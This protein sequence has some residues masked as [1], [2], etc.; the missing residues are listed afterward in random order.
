MK[1]QEI[2]WPSDA[3]SYFVRQG[4]TVE[5]AVRSGIRPVTKTQV[6]NMG[7]HP[8]LDSLAIPYFDPI[9]G[10]RLETLRFRYLNPPIIEGEL[11]R[12]TQSA[13]TPVEAYFDPAVN[14]RPILK[15]PRVDLLITEGEFKAIVANKY[16][17]WCIAL[18]GVDS[19]HQKDSHLLTPL[20]RKVV[21]R[22]RRVFICYDSDAATNPNVQR[23]ERQLAE[24]LSNA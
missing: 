12:Y 19:W 15:D 11:R 17:F 22:G 1:K 6:H 21:W 9:T 20:L 10:Q 5:D 4:I 23:A 14:W 3:L 13:G 7:G 2:V 18:G 24:A 16:G 8:A